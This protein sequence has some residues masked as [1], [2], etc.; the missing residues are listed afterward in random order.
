METSEAN[1]R[2]GVLRDD[3]CV[4]STLLDS[5]SVAS[6]CVMSASHQVRKSQRRH[7]VSPHVAESPPHHVRL[8]RAEN[9]GANIPCSHGGPEGKLVST[10]STTSMLHVVFRGPNGR[11]GCQPIGSAIVEADFESLLL[12]LAMRHHFASLAEFHCRSPQQAAYAMRELDELGDVDFDEGD[13]LPE[14]F[15]PAE[16]IPAVDGLLRH[17]KKFSALLRTEL[18]MLRRVLEEA[19]RRQCKFCLMDPEPN[20]P[21]PYRKVILVK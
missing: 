11:T 1:A 4:D 5:A 16:G 9:P 2:D 21:M 20:E 3:T 18:E 6:A 17:G 12:N 10:V 19:G 7:A 13:F 15:D 8:L 14:Y